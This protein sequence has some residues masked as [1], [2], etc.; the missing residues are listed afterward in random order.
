MAW[1]S[2]IFVVSDVR[3]M[4]LN[5]PYITFLFELWLLLV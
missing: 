4:T 3:E 2:G 1:Y 5:V